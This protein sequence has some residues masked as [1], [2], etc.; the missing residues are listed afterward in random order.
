MSVTEGGSAKAAGVVQGLN[1]LAVN[2]TPVMGLE[3]KDVVAAIKN[4]SG[5][6]RLQ[7]ERPDTAAAAAAADAAAADAADAAGSG[8]GAGAGVGVEV[9]VDGDGD[10]DGNRVG[11]TAHAP[12]AVVV[13]EASDD[14]G[15]SFPGD[16]GDTSHTGDPNA[17]Y[18]AA[19]FDMMDTR[20]SGCIGAQEIV[21]AVEVAG[22]NSDDQLDNRV[23]LTDLIMAQLE[24]TE[25]G[26]VTRE[27]FMAKVN[28][29]TFPDENDIDD[30]QEEYYADMLD[31]HSRETSP[32]RSPGRRHREQ[33][34]RVSSISQAHRD[35]FATH[36]ADAD[37][38]GMGS[39][40]MTQFKGMVR[41][42]SGPEF[43]NIDTALVISRV[44]GA[45]GDTGNRVG[46]DD[47]LFAF[48]DCAGDA[49]DEAPG[50]G[51]GGLQGG[52]GVRPGRSSS[53]DVDRVYE[54]L[55]EE[56]RGHANER[57]KQ[58]ENRREL[59]T[60]F[61]DSH[62]EMELRVSFVETREAK[63]SN[64]YKALQQDHEDLQRTVGDLKGEL[65]RLEERQAGAGVPSD[66][67][68]RGQ[69]AAEIAEL[70][71][72]NAELEA[73]AE[74]REAARREAE[75]A[76][77][78]AREVCA[79][80]EEN[81]ATLR[82]QLEMQEAH[83]QAQLAA[84][85][86]AMRHRLEEAAYA[87]ESAEADLSL[88]KK[89]V[90]ALEHKL[91]ASEAAH[92]PGPADTA[93]EET[94][95]GSVLEVN[96]QDIADAHLMR[97]QARV[98]ELEGELASLRAELLAAEENEREA[99]EEAVLAREASGAREAA[100]AAEIQAG[101]AEVDALKAKLELAEAQADGYFDL[102]REV[103]LLKT[104]L[105]E[106]EMNRVELEDKVQRVVADKEAVAAQL[107]ETSEELAAADEEIERLR[108][109]QA[110]AIARPGPT[111]L[112]LAPQ[113]RAMRDTCDEEIKRQYAIRHEERSMA[114]MERMR[115]EKAVVDMER[116]LVDERAELAGER[117]DKKR[118]AARAANEAPAMQ[119]SNKDA[120]RVQMLAGAGRKAHGAH[121]LASK[122]PAPVPELLVGS[123]PPH[124]KAVVRNVPD[125]VPQQVGSL[126]ARLASLEEE[127]ARLNT[128]NA[129]LLAQAT[130][131]A[132]ALGHA[133]RELADAR[134]RLAAS[135]RKGI[136]SKLAAEEMSV[137]KARLAAAA[138][139]AATSKQREQLLQTRLRGNE[140]ENAGLLQER[141]TLKREVREYTAAARAA[142]QELDHALK[143]FGEDKARL[144]AEVGPSWRP[145]Q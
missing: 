115:L 95:L 62:N 140:A 100:D 39:L 76:A 3:K 129:T 69:Y 17:N 103:V 24:L 53:Y 110:K 11:S 29:S 31:M 26:A 7:L 131:A 83:A 36:F 23:A 38:D 15:A 6:V 37:T 88:E 27:E 109:A 41:R 105:V 22:W 18:L 42:A 57:L 33:R 78:E 86:G 94:T 44:F 32:V 46:F 21:D 102:K 139:L 124:P 16:T 138:A 98:G 56:R 49:G 43:D 54:K 58:Q 137:L 25:D 116:A 8:S 48:D 73:Q 93:E 120:L 144:L 13:R 80:L 111:G 72:G 12:P 59:E 118:Q 52:G 141:N 121:L 1:I 63:T 60:F 10:G 51:G 130:T 20:K 92:Q 66:A 126:M 91:E 97:S 101:R 89:R 107:Y 4:S 75:A 112:A 77:G 14:G 108:S 65:R 99:A 128:A 90:T 74:V 96:V 5:P 79:L 28:L 55:R 61:E 122:A 85:E 136:S 9:E 81:E 47:L 119:G 35:L 2:G 113:L 127:V 117:A 71:R 50:G 145:V 134:A 64:K 67:A 82:G 142:E 30:E 84:Q 106:E 70:V 87:L 132:T 133:G 40:S 45:D 104:K 19:L 135:Q 125:V 68:V 143:R 123:A 34:Q 114:E